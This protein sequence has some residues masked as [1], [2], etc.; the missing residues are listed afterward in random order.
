MVR[1][2][3]LHSRHGSS[4]SFGLDGQGMTRRNG[5]FA[6]CFHLERVSELS[7]SRLAFAS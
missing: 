6:Y 2:N 5:G 4:V 3:C 7:L 1:E